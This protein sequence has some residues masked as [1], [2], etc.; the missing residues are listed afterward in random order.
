[1]STFCRLFFC[2]WLLAYD[3]LFPFGQTPEME[4]EMNKNIDL[5]TV[6]GR[7]KAKRIEAGM[8]QEQLAEKLYVKFSMI[9]RYE[10]AKS[11]LSVDTLKE[12]AEALGC[13]AAYLIEGVELELS[14]EEKELIKIF[15]SLNRD[16][17]RKVAMEQLRILAGI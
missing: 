9:S 7:I 10:S 2:L 5:P 8:T 4:T 12:I 17:V 6:G 1:M 3:G 14:E 15:K 16:E 11:N 13:S